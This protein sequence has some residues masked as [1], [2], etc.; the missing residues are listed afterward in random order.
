MFKKLW[1][2]VW[3]NKH[4]KYLEI[5]NHCNPLF[6]E[7]KINIPIYVGQNRLKNEN[8][9]KGSF[10]LQTVSAQQPN[11]F[12]QE[13]LWSFSRWVPAYFLVTVCIYCS[14]LHVVL[15]NH[16]RHLQGCP[17]AA[18]LSGRLHRQNPHSCYESGRSKL[19]LPMQMKHL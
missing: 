7:A 1:V 8:H 3:K 5:C 13:V 6:W 18:A 2:V 9:L 14:L 16:Y 11:L 10:A 4:V 17:A 19:D 12:M 15:Q